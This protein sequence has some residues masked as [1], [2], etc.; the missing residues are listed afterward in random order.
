M[1]NK[2]LARFDIKMFESYV[3]LSHILQSALYILAK[4]FWKEDLALSHKKPCIHLMSTVGLYNKYYHLFTNNF[5]MKVLLA[6]V[7]GPGNIFLTGTIRK[8]SKFIPGAA[9]R[10]ASL[11]S[12]NAKC[13][14]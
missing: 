11:I 3:I 13:Y 1:A 6:N 12:E 7:L 14:L 8:T 9:C 5:Y 2:C 4:V 10:L